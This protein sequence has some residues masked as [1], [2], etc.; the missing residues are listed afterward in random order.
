MQITLVTGVL[1][2]H[3]S[4]QTQ[5]LILHLQNLMQIMQIESDLSG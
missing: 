3:V 1:I 2:L 5:K 4:L